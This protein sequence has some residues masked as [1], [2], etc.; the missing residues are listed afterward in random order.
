MFEPWVWL[1]HAIAISPLLPWPWKLPPVPS[2]FQNLFPEAFLKDS[3]LGKLLKSSVV[4]CCILCWHVLLT[5]GR[6]PVLKISCKQWV[7]SFLP[8]PLLFL[9]GWLVGCLFVCLFVRLRSFVCLVFSAL[10]VFCSWKLRSQIPGRSK[11]VESLRPLDH[12]AWTTNDL[13]GPAVGDDFGSS[14]VFAF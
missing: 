4:S 9:V 10:V 1:Q 3:L 2:S 8:T 12:V 7:I 13:E 11:Q 6:T 14:K 5:V